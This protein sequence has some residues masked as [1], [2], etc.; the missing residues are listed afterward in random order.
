MEYDLIVVG[1]GSSGGAAAY[2]ASKEGLKTLLIERGKESGDKSTQA[3]GLVPVFWNEEPLR[4]LVEEIR[5]SIPVV[6]SERRG[7]AAYHYVDRNNEVVFEYMYRP[8][9]EGFKVGYS[10]KLCDF[11]KEISRRA[12]MEGAELRT[13]CTVV[14]VIRKDNQV[15]GILTEN[16]EEI[17]GKMVIGADGTYSIIAKKTGLL[18]KWKE[19]EV[20]LGYA[21]TFKMAEEDIEEAFEGLMHCFFGPNVQAYAGHANW[22]CIRAGGGVQFCV[23][24]YLYQVN[25]NL[26]WYL[27]NLYKLKTVRRLM[28]KAEGFPGKPI[29]KSATTMPYLRYLEKLYTPGVMIVGDAAGQVDPFGMEGI[30]TGMAAGMFAAETAKEAL[31]KGD[32]SEKTLVEYQ[33]KWEVSEFAQR[34]VIG[35]EFFKARAITR[36]DMGS[37]PLEQLVE[38]MRLI[39]PP[40]MIGVPRSRKMS[41]ILS[42]QI[43]T[44][45]TYMINNYAPVIPKL[46]PDILYWM[47]EHT[48]SLKEKG[49]YIHP[50][51]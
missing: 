38:N 30:H 41:D 25:R 44:K 28:E 8:P 42:W 27:E 7:G 18:T 48:K 6:S 34:W 51:Y 40:M 43:A 2:I 22:S 46:L 1:A 37:S 16:G 20:I 10:C 5:D 23:L 13:S 12:V 19:N 39:G 47:E 21:E 49:V 31:E 45:L 50:W 17:H 9:G 11:N 4:K 15:C 24:A 35:P 26:K 36:K 29:Q 33:K 32:F 3:S 14:D